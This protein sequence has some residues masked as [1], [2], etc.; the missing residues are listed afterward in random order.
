MEYKIGR[1]HGAVLFLGQGE[2]LIYGKRTIRV[3]AVPV[4]DH[5]C[6][7]LANIL[8]VDPIPPE[9]SIHDLFHIRADSDA[10]VDIPI[11]VAD[12]LEAGAVRKADN[13]PRLQ[14]GRDL[15]IQLREHGK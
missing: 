12:R 3:F 4:F 15:D 14:T 8:G 5:F 13:A 2:V 11:L 1:L 10:D 6:F 7:G 9:C